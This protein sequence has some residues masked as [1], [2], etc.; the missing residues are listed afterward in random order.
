MS[1]LACCEFDYFLRKQIL[2]FLLHLSLVI[3]FP[4]PQEFCRNEAL[5]VN[6][7]HVA[8]PHGKCDM[9]DVRE[10]QVAVNSIFD[11]FFILMRKENFSYF[12]AWDNYVYDKNEKKKLLDKCFTCLTTICTYKIN[13]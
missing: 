12:F 9:F 5:N 6:K 1:V 11:N 4:F 7:Q 2:E 3:F 10:L 8:V 13:V